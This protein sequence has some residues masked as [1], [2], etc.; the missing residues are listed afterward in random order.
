[1]LLLALS[2]SALTGLQATCNLAH[3]VT[4]GKSGDCC[5][6]QQ[7]CKEGSSETLPRDHCTIARERPNS[8]QLGMHT[9]IFFLNLRHA[10]GHFSCMQLDC[11][12]A[13]RWA[14]MVP[15]NKP[16]YMGV[17]CSRR[18]SGGP[19]TSARRRGKACRTADTS[20]GGQEQIHQ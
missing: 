17:G 11:N 1:M 15:D 12:R 8:R 19:G 13:S 4:R 20:P 9:V 5:Q 7:I 10:G 16:T 6:L 2:M 18:G 14:R 3:I